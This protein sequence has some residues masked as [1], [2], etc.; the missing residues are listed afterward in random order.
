[1]VDSA[2]SEIRIA[3]PE[4]KETI[5]RIYNAVVGSDAEHEALWDKLIL[6]GGLVAARIEGQIVGFGGIDI[7][8]AEQVKW[9]YLLPEHQ[10]AGFGSEILRRL[11]SIGWGAGLE[12]LRLHSA[13]GAVN[14]YRRHGYRLVETAAQLGHDH[15][16]VELMN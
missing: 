13:L 14:F 16:G 6:Q 4:D 12:S 5:Q 11:E 8:A 2:M 9:L 10:G 7:H 3:Q 15:E 1:M